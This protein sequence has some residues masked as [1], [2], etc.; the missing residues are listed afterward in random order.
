MEA[1]LE[2]AAMETVRALKDRRPAVRRRA[3]PKK[4]IQGDG[5]PWQKLAI[6]RGQ[7]I[8]RRSCT[9]QGTQA[10]GTGQGRCYK[11]SH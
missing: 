5:G 1:C 7:L 8:R 9:A 3:W 4:R 10:S 2:E 6:T 11:R